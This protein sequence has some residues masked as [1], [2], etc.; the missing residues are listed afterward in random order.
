[1]T[2]VNVSAPLHP[3]TID[4]PQTQTYY[5]VRLNFK[6][7]VRYTRASGKYRG[8]A[9]ETKYLWSL[10]DGYGPEYVFWR[11]CDD[12]PS[13]FRFPSVS[14]ARAAAKTL[15]RE[16]YGEDAC[17]ERLIEKVTE[18]LERYSGVRAPVDTPKLDSVKGGRDCKGC[19]R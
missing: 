11:L 17:C 2:V 16:D 13:A 10:C 18:R 19:S 15:S 3:S 14:K 12:R 6:H 4:Y 7:D 8:R 1:M 5:V 9:G